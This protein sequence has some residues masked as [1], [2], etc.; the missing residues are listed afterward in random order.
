MLKD[1]DLA[2]DFVFLLANLKMS[3]DSFLLDYWYA[4][5]SI[6]YSKSK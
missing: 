2:M 5:N 6:S 3:G 4:A 1:D